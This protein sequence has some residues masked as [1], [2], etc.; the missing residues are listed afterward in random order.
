MQLSRRILLASSAAT[1]AVAIPAT[2]AAH[3]NRHRPI[4][5]DPFNLGVASGDPTPTAW[6]CGPAWP[7]TPWP[8]TAWAA[9]RTAP[10][11]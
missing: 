3:D 7:S 11:T 9:Y 2:A 8:K 10:T 4:R 1:A 6:C 5:T